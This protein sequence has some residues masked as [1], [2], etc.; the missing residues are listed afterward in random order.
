M[1]DPETLV[2]QCFELGEAVRYV[3]VLQAGELLMRQRTGIADASAG[4]SDRYE[5]LLVN[6]TILTLAR[7]RGDIDCGGLAWVLIRYGNFFTFVHPTSTGHLSV[8]IELDA[9]LDAITAAL[10]RTAGNWDAG[11]VPARRRQGQ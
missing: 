2:S 5:E 6:P 11:A 4:E 7:R 9:E 10:A 8:G 1:P 3:A